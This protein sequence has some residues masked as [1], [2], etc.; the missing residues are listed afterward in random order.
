VVVPFNAYRVLAMVGAAS[1]INFG[2][3]IGTN[4]FAA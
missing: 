3:L 1:K 2:V 4:P